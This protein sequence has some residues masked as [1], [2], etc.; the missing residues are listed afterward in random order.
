MR[1]LLLWVLA[2]VLSAGIMIYQRLTGPTSP[3]RGSIEYK[4]SKVS[5]KLIRTW[6]DDSGAKIS[7][8]TK[9]DEATGYLMYRRFKSHDDWSRVEMINNNGVLEAILPKLPPAGKMMYKIT[10]S[11]GQ[12]EIQLTE[13]P[14]ILRYKGGVPTGIIIPHVIFMILSILFS[15][16]AGIEAVAKRKKIIFQSFM[17]TATLFIGGLILGPIVQKYAFDAYWTGWPV[18]HDLTDNKTAVSFIMWLVALLIIRK[19]PEKRGWV[20][21]AS[22]IQIVVYLI[23]HSVLG[24]EID[25]TQ[26]P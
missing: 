22:I 5:Y 12:N 3:V 26:T 4:N 18:G 2:L 13:E 6:G 10:L 21:A 1:S 25:F 14:V 23:P 7:V 19:K 8:E 9:D 11:D 20:I 15:M 16:R 24:S 17:A